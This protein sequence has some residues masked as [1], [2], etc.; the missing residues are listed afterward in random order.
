MTI[1]VKGFVY[2][3]KY[4]SFLYRKFVV[5]ALEAYLQIKSGSMD[6]RLYTVSL[7]GLFRKRYDVYLGETLYMTAKNAGF[8]S[9]GDMVVENQLSQ[10]LAVLKRNLYSM[11]Y[12]F[13]IEIP[14]EKKSYQLHKKMLSNHYSIGTDKSTIEVIGNFT[15]TEYT[16]Y[17]NKTEIAKVSRKRWR[18]E[19][20]YGIAIMGTADDLILLSVLLCIIKLRQIRK[21]N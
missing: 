2:L 21:N 4:C 1:N 5:L 13:E 9:F 10:E 17:C 19:K 6:V 7:R 20:S 14:S 12:K 16:F 3:S 18:R 11:R 15:S 8:W